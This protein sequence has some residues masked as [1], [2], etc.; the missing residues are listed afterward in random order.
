MC[1]ERARSSQ[2]PSNRTDGDDPVQD[3]SYFHIVFPLCFFVGSSGTWQGENVPPPASGEV[4]KNRYSIRLWLAIGRYFSVAL[5][6]LHCQMPLLPSNAQIRELRHNTVL[7]QGR[8]VDGH[9]Q[10]KQRLL[11]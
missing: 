11:G 2:T 5:S 3:G 4:V 6:W 1:S 8:M 7:V 9:T 10:R